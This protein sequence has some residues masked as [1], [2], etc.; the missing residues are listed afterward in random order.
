MSIKQHMLLAIKTAAQALAV[1]S[2]A[3]RRDQLDQVLGSH[4]TP[5]AL[6]P[7]EPIRPV[8][9]TLKDE[10]ETCPPVMDI[11]DRARCAEVVS[12]QLAA[13]RTPIAPLHNRSGAGA[14]ARQRGDDRARSTAHGRPAL[15]QPSAF[16][17]DAHLETTIASL[18]WS[19]LDV[20]KLHTATTLAFCAALEACG[21]PVSERMAT[22]LRQQISQN[23][24]G[25]W[26][27][28]TAAI[29]EVLEDGARRHAC[30]DNAANSR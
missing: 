20:V 23:E 22:N 11:A 12:Q 4:E 21:S 24:R 9:E 25:P 8:S 26:S 13:T 28:V 6:R 17:M 10:R 7:I 19:P 1:P 30:N 16:P 14:A 15:A 29:A 18:G 3:R 2:G 5:A 27:M